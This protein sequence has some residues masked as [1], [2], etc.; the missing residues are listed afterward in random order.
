MRTVIF[1]MK[2][3]DL[4]V[5]LVPEN[6]INTFAALASIGYKPLV[7]ITASQFANP[8]FSRCVVHRAGE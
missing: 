4:V 7:P 8:D 3:V 1:A 6:I 5:H 2:G